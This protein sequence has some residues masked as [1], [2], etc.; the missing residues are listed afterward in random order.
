[1]KAKVLNGEVEKGDTVAYS[2]RTGSHQDMNIGTVLDVVE[3]AHPYLHG[4]T[5]SGLRVE[6]TRTSGH[7][8]NHQALLRVLDRVVKL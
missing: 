1:M 7:R 6:V 4:K 5:S 3:V 8:G 2:T